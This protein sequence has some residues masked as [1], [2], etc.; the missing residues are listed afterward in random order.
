MSQ[1]LHSEV[2]TLISTGHLPVILFEMLVNIVHPSLATKGITYETY[3]VGV[4]EYAEYEL[5][6]GLTF[7]MM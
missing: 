1:G 3:M 2:D 5:N 6:T 4:D 7:I